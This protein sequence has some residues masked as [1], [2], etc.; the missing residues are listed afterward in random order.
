[1]TGSGR[2]ARAVSCHAWSPDKKF[3]ALSPNNSDVL[4][5]EAG[6][7]DATQWKLVHTLSEHDSF[8]SGIDWSSDN[9][10]VTC[11]H[12]RNAYVWN[13]D[14][15]TKAWKP[16]LVILRISRAATQVKWSPSGKKFAVA[17]GAKLVPVCHYEPDN[18]WWV[19]NLIKKHKST[20]LALA[21]HPNS[22]FLLTG[23]CD[24]KARIFSAFLS[25]VEE[26][27][28]A[29]VWGSIFPAHNQFGECL[30]EFDQ[31]SGWVESVA[32]SPSGKSLAWTSH[33]SCLNFASIDGAQPT[34][35]SLNHP[36]LPFVD[37]AFLGDNTVVAVG[38][39]HNG[40]V[41]V[42]GGSEWSFVDKIDKEN[43]ASEKK[44]ATGFKK[45]INAFKES[46]NKG[47][48]VGKDA[49]DTGLKTIHQNA[50]FQI[51]PF[52]AKGAKSAKEVVT[53]GIDG[54]LQFWNLSGDAAA[55]KL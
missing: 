2:I 19:S 50:I 37:I 32:F 20:V 21:W 4:I 55:Y 45:N 15:A 13:W 16:S 25:E 24:F 31:S 53:T 41:F 36:F 6:A 47:I 51:S 28:E 48:S 23:S 3:V 38:H 22:K 5:Y 11:G 35:F 7:G 26:D 43:N 39:N 33:D 46:T 29:D 52:F 17:S 9:M 27:V 49:G 42:N 30:W 10:I 40:F 1:M 18:N 12:D 44:E 54:R 8:V 14:T 34:V